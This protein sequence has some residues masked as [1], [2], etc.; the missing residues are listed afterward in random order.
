MSDFLPSHHELDHGWPACRIE[1]VAPAHTA[2]RG[3][4]LA[5]PSGSL[6]HRD[7]RYRVLRSRLWIK[8]GHR[9]PREGQ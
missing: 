3:E 7:I 6:A 2:V 8:H 1:S 5:R 4:R 9:L